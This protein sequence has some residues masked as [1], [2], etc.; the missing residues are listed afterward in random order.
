VNGHYSGSQQ[1]VSF[2]GFVPSRNPALTVIVMV[3]TPRVG[4]DT[5]GAVAAPI[6]HRIAEA[7]MRYLG[8]PPNINPAPPVM[9]A[10]RDENPVT[11]TKTAVTLPPIVTLPGGAES[12]VIP[13]LRGMSARDALRTLARLG[14]TARLRGHGL[15]IDQN[16]VAGTLLEP[17]ITCTLVLEREPSRQANGAGAIQ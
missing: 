1:N 10:R 17:G 11:Q 3:D 13:D 15:V 16:P 5:G 9:V 2:L 14:V 8:V 7:S 12:P 4:S 6:F